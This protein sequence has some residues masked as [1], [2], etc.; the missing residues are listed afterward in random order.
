ML[1]RFFIAI[2]FIIFVI[3]NLQARQSIIEAM[4]KKNIPCAA[5]VFY[6]GVVFELLFSCAILI[7]YYTSFAAMGL[8]IF[9]VVAILMF[10]AFWNMTGEIKRLNQII[11]ITNSTVVMGA[12]LS[13]VDWELLSEGLSWLKY[14][15]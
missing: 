14:I 6:F 3:L 11:F 2:F 8:I 4:H 7:D 12:L 1:S 15:R 13:L 5:F 9:D 10:H